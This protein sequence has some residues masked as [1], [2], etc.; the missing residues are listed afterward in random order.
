LEFLSVQATD[1]PSLQVLLVTGLKLEM[2]Q[3][4]EEVTDDDRLQLFES[5]VL[6]GENERNIYYGGL[7]RFFAGNQCLYDSGFDA[8]EGRSHCSC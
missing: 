8:V 7:Y 1:L 4:E 6:P 2:S 3:E 5:L